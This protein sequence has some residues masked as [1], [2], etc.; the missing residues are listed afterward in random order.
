MNDK[1]KL[2][3]LITLSI[4]LIVMSLPSNQLDAFVSVAKSL[5]FSGAAKMLNITQ[6]ALSQRILNLESELGSTLFI[7]ESSG[8]RL[9]D[10]GQRLLRYCSMKDS[11]E[12]EFLDHLRAENKATLG[13]IIRIGGFSTVVR[14]VLIPSLNQMI[15]KNSN[16]QVEIYTKEVQQLPALLETGAADFIMLNRACEKQGVENVLIGHELN[17]LVEP[18]NTNFQA[19]IFLDHDQNDTTTIDFFKIQ[20]N[21]P[22]T[23]RRSFFDEI[24]T[25][26]DGVL[27]G[28]GR[29][30][31]PIHLLKNQKNLKISKG[32]Q[33]LKTPVYFCYY[34]QPFY[35][36]LQKEVIKNIEQIAPLLL[37]QKK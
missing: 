26:I 14:S 32:Y 2:I 28:A 6:S 7:R 8:I 15:N 10:L 37:T 11:L 19:D 30:V 21:P 13:G 36:A 34:R 27:A 4:Y 24:Y 12:S 18:K 22:K 5:S 20:K 35:T 25:I 33:P 1:V 29:A 17:V 31:L 3:D 9:T 16:L 23:I